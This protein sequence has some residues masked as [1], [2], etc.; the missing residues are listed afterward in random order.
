MPA[1]TRQ[2]PGAMRHARMISRAGKIADVPAVRRW[3][4]R[5]QTVYDKRL[6]RDDSPWRPV[7]APVAD[8]C[9]ANG[10]LAQR[11]VRVATRT[12]TAAIRR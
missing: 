1:V 8:A 6:A 11:F 7:V 5:Q 4:A 3:C 12:V 2:Y 9:L 10:V